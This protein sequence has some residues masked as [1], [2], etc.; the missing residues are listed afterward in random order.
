MKWL[1]LLLCLGSYLVVPSRFLSS[2][3]PASILSPVEGDSPPSVLEQPFADPLRGGATEMIPSSLFLSPPGMFGDLLEIEAFRQSIGSRIEAIA[4]VAFLS[5]FKISDNESPRPVDRVFVTGHYFNGVGRSLFASNVS[6]ANVYREMIGFEKTFLQGNASVGMRLPYFQLTGD[7][8]LNETRIGDVSV[9]L[10]YAFVNDRAMGDVFAGGLVVTAP[11]GPAL[12]FPGQSTVNPV[13]LQPWFGDL[14]NW[15]SLFVQG[16]LSVAVPTD[17]REAI[18]FFKSVGV[19][20]WLY[21]SDEPNRLLRA[22]VPDAELHLTSSLNHQGLDSLPI[23]FPFILDF[24]GGFYVFLRRAVLGVG[25][26][27][28]LTGP[29][30]YEYQVITNLNFRF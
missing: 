21:R 2:Q 20:Y 1:R 17:A 25:V 24:T 11:T 30:P 22:I 12:H 8:G 6:Y 14:W 10:K 29:K 5:S 16:F 13:I 7:P 19:G 9:L 4:P 27:A 3:E 15:K 28:P 26:G 23:G 18:L